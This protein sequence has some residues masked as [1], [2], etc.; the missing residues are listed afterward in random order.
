[1]SQIADPLVEVNNVAIGVLPNTVKFTEGLG[2]QKT[3]AISFGGGATGQVYSSDIETNFS[4][5]M[6]ELPATIENIALAR[7][8][9]I[10]K[11]QNVITIT[12]TVDGQSLTRVFTKASLPNDYEVSLATE[13][14]IPL[15]FNANKAV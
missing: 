8:W 7:A 2:E 4:K 9:K 11:N 1:M 14:N 15:E 3:R 6:F 10:N 13:G 12:A 5:V